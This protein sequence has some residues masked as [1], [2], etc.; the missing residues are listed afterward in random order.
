MG[1][2]WCSAE[3]AVCLAACPGS[4]RLGWP[5]AAVRPRACP[6]FAHDVPVQAAC[7]VGRDALVVSTEIR[8]GRGHLTITERK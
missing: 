3:D 7:A 5:G 6:S 4:V 8:E 2:G 1:V